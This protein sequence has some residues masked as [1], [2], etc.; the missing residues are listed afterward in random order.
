MPVGTS[1][2]PSA[3][4]IL[5]HVALGRGTQNYT[6]ANS[7]RDAVPVAAGALATLFNVTCL[8]APYTPLLQVLPGIALHFPVPITPSLAPVNLFLSGKH[9]FADL[10]TPTFDLDAAGHEWG[11]VGCKKANATD[12]PTDPK[13]NVPWLKLTSKSRDGC[14]ISEVYRVNTAGGQPPPTCEGQKPAFE[15]QYAAEYWMW[16]NPALGSYS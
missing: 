13:T 9:Y 1:L 15:V 4:L 16:S 14:T 3:G 7:T 11:K 2:P 6:C 5:Q 8:A 10:T 12:A